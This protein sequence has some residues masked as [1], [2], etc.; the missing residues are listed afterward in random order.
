MAFPEK[1]MAEL[2]SRNEIVSVVSSYV[3]LKPKG[4]RLWGRCPIHGERTPSFSVSPDKQ[5]FYC[6][7]CHAGGSVIQFVMA[8]EH[9]TYSETVRY[10]AERAGM[11]M[12]EEIDDTELQQ[13]KAYRERLQD[14]CRQ[15]ARY[16][17]ENLIS[18]QGEPGR[19]YL[20]GRGLNGE[21]VKHFGLGYA[22]DGWE[23]LKRHMTQA[24]FTEQELIDAGLLFFNERRNS[25]YDAYRNRIIFPIIG[26]TGNV[27]GF[28][29]RTITGDTPKYI[30]TGDTAIYNKRRNLYGLYLMKNEKLSD[31]VIV[32][33]Y[34]DVIGLYQAGIRNAVASLGTALTEQQARLIKRYVE[35]V[36]IAYDGDAPGQNAM[37]RGLDILKT[38]GLNVRVIVFPDDLDP[39]EFVR[40]RGRESFDKLKEE[41]LTLN[42]YKLEWMAKRYDLGN[43]NER[44]KYAVEACRFVAGLQPVEQ[45]RYYQQIAKKTGYSL[46]TLKNQGGKST[47]LREES[48][49]R[50]STWEFRQAAENP[51]RNERIRVEETVLYA[52]L[53][54]RQAASELEHLEGWKLLREPC[55]TVVKL[56]QEI[57]KQRKTPDL[58]DLLTRL[59]PDQTRFLSGALKED[60]ALQEPEQTVR[61]CLGRLRKQELSEEIEK[62]TE[63]LRDSALSDV[64]KKDRLRQIQKLV[65]EKNKI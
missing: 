1:W 37:I 28:G 27:L 52:V 10:L 49:R 8:M 5:L 3:S 31:L 15:A 60:Y 46:D 4:R 51:E 9:M 61:D 43:E 32:E 34:M 33:G 55:C 58:A 14:A 2:L 54:S 57:W 29:A 30:N 50:A 35:T 63:T 38:E 6:F 41:A 12:P 59:D 36:Y 25:A 13:K 64:E 44:E 42:A 16:Y 45:D 20:A 56:V 17:M 7:G 18:P 53:N 21:I 19:Q 62:I 65:Q 11:Q 26:I 22:P 24:G 48:A 40:Q 39:D 23:N 47:P